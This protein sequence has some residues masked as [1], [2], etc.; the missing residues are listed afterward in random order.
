MTHEEQ[1][2]SINGFFLD[3]WFQESSNTYK[4]GLMGGDTSP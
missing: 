1:A 3:D 4:L 2:Y